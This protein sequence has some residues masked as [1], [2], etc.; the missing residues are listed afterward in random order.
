MLVREDTAF[1]E[2]LETLEIWDTSEEFES[3]RLLRCCDDGLRGGKAG[4][5]S[6]ELVRLGKGGGTF[7]GGRTGDCSATELDVLVRRGR[8]GGLG[9]WGCGRGW[10]TGF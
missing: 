7:R 8:A 9:F 6:K 3:L 10:G 5:G 1:R 4:D 2:R